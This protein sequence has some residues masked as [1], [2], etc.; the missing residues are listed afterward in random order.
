[1]S[2]VI[3]TDII[4]KLQANNLLTSDNKPCE[5]IQWDKIDVFKLKVTFTVE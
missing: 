3:I 4:N 1:M 5:T 2:L